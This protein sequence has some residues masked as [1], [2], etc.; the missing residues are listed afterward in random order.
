MALVP[1]SG[2]SGTAMATSVPLLTGENFTTLAIMVE[3]DLDV[4]GL[5]EAVVPPE[6]ATLVVI[7]NKDKPARDN[8]NCRCPIPSRPAPRANR[9]RALEVGISRN[10]ANRFSPDLLPTFS[11]PPPS[12]AQT[13]RES[14]PAARAAYVSTQRA[15]RDL[16]AFTE[17]EEKVA[18]RKIMAGAKGKK[19]SRD[20]LVWTPEMDTALLAML[21]EHHNRGDHAQNGW[22]PHVYNACIKHVKETCDVVINKDKIIARIKTF[23]RQYD[24]I[25]KMLAQSGFGWDWD[26][27]MVMVESDEVWLRYV[28]A[29]KDA[30]YYR[31]KEVKNWQAIST[32]YS[33]DHATGAGAKT[34]AECAQPQSSSVAQVGDDDEETPEPPKKRA[35]AADAIL[36]MVGE[37]RCTFD[38]ALKTT[39][40]Q[41]VTPPSEI[42]AAL[43]EI[44]GLEGDDLLRAYGK[45]TANERTFESL[46]AL[47]RDLR[48]P[49]LLTL[50]R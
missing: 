28:E 41:K 13:R 45:L 48:K 10:L 4:A 32:I 21:V 25:S 38:E 36:S 2:G 24:I 15:P 22:K 47:P 40:A 12:R 14:S 7:A 30:A 27:N 16:G 29:N 20:Y 33:K 6:D 49:W 8:Q 37:L 17:F 39:D 5:W 26:N 35:R 42:L 18:Y 11:S 43:K 46:M 3:A 9:F 23:D 31:N 44:P 50:P 1:Y 34:G 19:P